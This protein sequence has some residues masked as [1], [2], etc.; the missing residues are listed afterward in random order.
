MLLTGFVLVLM[1]SSTVD[2]QWATNGNNINNTN[3]GNVGHRHDNPDINARLH[4]YNAPSSGVDV[5][6]ANAGVG[7]V[8]GL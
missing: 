4:V 6:S 7:R 3:T 1:L 2:A 8:Y 5:Q